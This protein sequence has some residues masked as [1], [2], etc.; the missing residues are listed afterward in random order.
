MITQTP[1]A[2][3]LPRRVASTAF[4][5]LLVLGLPLAA[6]R[7]GHSG[8]GRRWRPLG[9]LDGGGGSSHSSPRLIALGLRRRPV[10]PMGSPAAA[11]AAA[12]ASRTATVAATAASAAMA[13][14]AAAT[15]TAAT[16]TTTPMAGGFGF[17]PGF[18]WLW[19]GDP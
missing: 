17:W 5:A 3:R 8:G 4:A 9:S 1:A 11:P 13:A 14:T 15:G 7:G 10:R 6:Q 2:S 19:Y 12:S 18:S 16:I